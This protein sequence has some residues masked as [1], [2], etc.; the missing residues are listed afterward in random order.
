MSSRSGEIGEG[1]WSDSSFGKGG[2]KSGMCSGGF[3][4]ASLARF[5]T[6]EP[7]IDTGERGSGGDDARGGVRAGGGIGEIVI[8]D[9]ARFRGC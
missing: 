1:G 2:R 9:R 7:G 4:D 3:Q 8:G 6:G 5:R